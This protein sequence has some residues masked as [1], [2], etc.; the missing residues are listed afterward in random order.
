MKDAAPDV[1]FP[2]PP[3]LFTIEDVGGWDAV[4][5]KFFDRDNGVVAKIEQD[6]G[7]STDS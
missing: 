5:D 7:V 3:Q 2:D 6:M 4:M 1:T